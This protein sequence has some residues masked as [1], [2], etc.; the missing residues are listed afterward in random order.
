MTRETRDS[1]G[2]IFHRRSTKQAHLSFGEP[3][4][5][6]KELNTANQVEQETKARQ[7]QQIDF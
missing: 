6:Q 1:V 4:I 5:N 3:R 2:G 7:G